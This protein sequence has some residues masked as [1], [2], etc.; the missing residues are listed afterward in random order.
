MLLKQM[1]SLEN[2]YI[3]YN[4]EDQMNR[5]GQSWILGSDDLKKKIVPDRKEQKM[6]KS[7]LRRCFL[8]GTDTAIRS[9]LP[10]SF[11]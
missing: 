10:H 4:N 1:S 8:G 2:K 3:R 9:V 11:K 6:H 7:S 5:K